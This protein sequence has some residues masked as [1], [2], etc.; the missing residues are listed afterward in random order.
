MLV[1]VLLLQGSGCHSCARPSLQQHQI[2]TC[3]CF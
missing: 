3:G 1:L 2:I